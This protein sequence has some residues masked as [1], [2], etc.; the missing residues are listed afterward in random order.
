MSADAVTHSELRSAIHTRASMRR[1]GT[2]GLI[3]VGLWLTGAAPMRALPSGDDAPPP[4]VVSARSLIPYIS[5]SRIVFPSGLDV[6][7]PA[8][9]WIPSFSRQTKLACSACHYG[10]PQLT[11]FGRMFKLNGYT[12]SAVNT[13]TAR[14]SSRETLYL[15]SLGPLSAMFVT[16]FTHTTTRQTDADASPLQNNT[17]SFPQQLS[18]FL[19]GAISQHVGAFA[20]LTYAAPDGS[21]G[22]DNVDIRFANHATL[23]SKELIYGLT[24]NN[25]PTVQ[26]P[27]N[28]VPAWGFPFI[29]SG[30]APSPGAATL[31]DGGLGQQVLGV[32]AYGLWNK[33]VYAE[34]SAYRSAQQGASNPPSAAS[35]NVTHN[36]IPY[37]HILIR[38]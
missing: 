24:L 12:L 5:G 7:A 9:R 10:F 36:I 30:E 11:P 22:I 14:D 8:A 35:A 4:A 19:A 37:W 3:A 31:I 34:F 20:Q 1:H 28:T 27:W 18:L 13:I 21:I 16:G 15:S 25:N 17:L 32:G 33:L 26:D 29:A 6:R 23:A 2:R 38:P